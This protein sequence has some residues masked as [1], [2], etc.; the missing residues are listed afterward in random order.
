MHLKLLFQARVWK[1]QILNKVVEYGRNWHK[2]IETFGKQEVSSYLGSC[3]ELDVL[4][5]SVQVSTEVVPQ[6]NDAHF[7]RNAVESARTDDV[8]LVRQSLFVVLELHCLQELNA[9]I[10][11]RDIWLEVRTAR[12][13]PDENIDYRCDNRRFRVSA[14]NCQV[15]T[16]S[17]QNL[18]LEQR[19]RIFGAD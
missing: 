9:K 12:E 16:P 14:H 2:K 19:I 15:P 8:H 1:C 5:N 10:V 7:S 3:F 18:E 11:K 17:S 6:V 4:L 13:T